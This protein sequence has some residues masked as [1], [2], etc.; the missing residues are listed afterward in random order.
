MLNVL[1]VFE[2]ARAQYKRG[3]LNFM[4]IIHNFFLTLNI[5]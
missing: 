3:V 4:L 5:K 1:F 2:T